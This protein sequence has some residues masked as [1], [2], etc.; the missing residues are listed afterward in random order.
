MQDA[1]HQD[2]LL[3]PQ[4]CDVKL[5]QPGVRRARTR[6]RPSKC[7][8]RRCNAAFSEEHVVRAFQT[9]ALPSDQARQMSRDGLA[10][11][12]DKGPYLRV[13]QPKPDRYPVERRNTVAIREA[14]EQHQ[15]ARLNG[16]E[17]QIF[18]GLRDLIETQT[19]V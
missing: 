15:K 9:K 16:G 14:I 13:R 1:L 7:R 5:P 6:S 17:R 19:E 3:W 11:A 8:V 4:N 10:R 18:D 2:D 12:S